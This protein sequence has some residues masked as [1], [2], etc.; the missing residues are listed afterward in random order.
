LHKSKKERETSRKRK[1][2]RSYVEVQRRYADQNSGAQVLHRKYRGFD[3]IVYVWIGH[4]Q[5]RKEL[6][7]KFIINNNIVP[8]R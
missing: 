6:G 5:K 4:M 2:E 1:R 3:V 7:K 8:E